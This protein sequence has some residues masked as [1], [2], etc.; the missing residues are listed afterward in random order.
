MSIGGVGVREGVAVALLV[1]AGD[2]SVTTTDAMLLALVG[3]LTG[4]APAL[5]GG[6]LLAISR[7]P[8]RPTSAALAR[9][10]AAP[11][12]IASA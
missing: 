4:Q 2:G 12:A 10:V 5:L 9:P 1:S 8:A 7:D 11:S 6:I 3:Y